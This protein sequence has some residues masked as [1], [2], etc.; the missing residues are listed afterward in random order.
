MI[1]KAVK[2]KTIQKLKPAGPAI[3]Y[4]YSLIIL[5]YGFVAVATPNMNTLDSLGPKFMT[6]AILNLAAYL[7]LFT[8][9]EI[10]NNL[11]IELHFFKTLTGLVYV[12]FLVV[13]LLSFTKA[14]N[15]FESIINY[16]KLFTLFSA[17]YIVSLILR[18]DK[19]Y[20]THL[21]VGMT[22]LLIFDSLTVFYHISTNIMAGKGPNIIEIKSVYSNKNILAAAIFVK[23]PFAL[24]LMTFSKNILRVFGA[25]AL[26]LAFLATLFMSTR[27]FYIGAIVLFLV[28]LA[29]M[30]IRNYR[31]GEKNRLVMGALY[32]VATIVLGFVIFTLTLKYLYPS[33]GGD[34]YS[35]DVISRLKTI[36]QGGD[37]GVNLRTMAWKNSFLLIKEHPMLGVGTGNWKI[38]VLKYENLKGV[39]YIYM[40]KNHND[41]IETTAETG[42]FGGLLFLM[43]FILTGYNFVRAFLKKDAVESGYKYLFLPAL[44]LLCYSFDALF[45]FPADRPEIASLF[46]IYTGAGIAF[47]SPV[48]FFRSEGTP[49]KVNTSNTTPLFLGRSFL[50]LCMLGSFYFLYQ[51]V[52]SLTTQRLV[53]ED[54]NRGTLSHPSEI[55]IAGFPVIPNISVEGEPLAVTKSRYL[56]NEGKFEQ[57]IALLKADRSSPYDTRQE[58][59]IS[60]A[61]FKLAQYDSALKYALLVLHQKPHFGGNI[62]NLGAILTTQGKP[63]EALEIVNTY[64]E[65]LKVA[66]KQ[67]NQQI[68]DLKRDLEQKALLG[69][70][71]NLYKSALQ[72]YDSKSYAKA[73]KIFTEII[74]TVPGL[75]AA[76]EYRAFCYFMI[77]AYEKSIADVNRVFADGIQKPNL[78]NLRGVNYEMLGNRDAACADF[79]KAIELGDKDAPGNFNRACKNVK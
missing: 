20:L 43:V 12:A 36:S 51:N 66:D 67:P 23:I 31:R 34:A 6:L 37:A 10:R 9:K 21:A 8:G 48:K 47:A 24:W 38:E 52:K 35:V 79:S 64:L 50:I 61:Y 32:V 25:A 14:I 1:K 30:I 74:G 15:I 68:L 7:L 54:Q 26:F 11:R 65:R 22:S 40:Y 63:G 57:A 29:F 55:I 75:T 16:S 2:P 4:L 62:Y 39:D 19:R 46:A 27:A 5:V 72:L 42:I 44:G 41:F 70:V 77:K 69:P 18:T 17:A 71:E 78:M 73:E 28:Y 33:S 58:F 53:K 59:F 45:N 56:N 60:Y 76:Y 13:A 3:N 49:G